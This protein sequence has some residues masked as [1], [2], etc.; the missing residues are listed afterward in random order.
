MSNKE[1]FKDF[2]AMT[3]K[4][5]LFHPINLSLSRVNKK[6]FQRSLQRLYFDKRTTAAP[7]ED[8]HKMV[9]IYFTIRL[10]SKLFLICTPL[11]I[12]WFCIYQS[13]LISSVIKKCFFYILIFSNLVPL[14]IIYDHSFEIT[15]SLQFKKHGYI[16]AER[17][18]D[19]LRQCQSKFRGA[20][21]HAP[22]LMSPNFL[23]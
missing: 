18:G 11:A 2:E 10:T 19:V 8:P 22:T 1:D 3:E 15:E 6:L 12:V 21:P 14:L 5:R 16:S 13:I 23:F 9:G 7:Q 4:N 20:H 17:T